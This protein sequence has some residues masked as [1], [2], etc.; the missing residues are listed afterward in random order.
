[1][2]ITTKATTIINFKAQTQ[3]VDAFYKKLE[4]GS[5]VPMSEN[6][7][8]G[9]QALTTEA[10]QFQD[11]IKQIPDDQITPD[12]YEEILKKQKMLIKEGEKLN[13]KLIKESGTAVGETIDKIKNQ[14]SSLQENI[15]ETRESISKEEKK[16][17]QVQDAS[18]ET[19]RKFNVK[20]DET[21]FM[22]ETAEGMGLSD[23]MKGASGKNIK[24]TK[25]MLE[26]TQKID[27]T[28]QSST[29]A[30]KKINE[31]L[32]SG[33][34]AQ[35]AIDSLT[36]KQRETLEKRIKLN[37]KNFTLEEAIT[38]VGIKRT[39]DVEKESFLKAKDIQIADKE[40]DLAAKLTEEKKL[41]A[42][43]NEEYRKAQERGTKEQKEQLEYS[44]QLGNTLLGAGSKASTAYKD[45]QGQIKGTNDSL[46]N[47]TKELHT[48][49]TTL[50]RAT[51]Q[52]FNYGIAF[53]A[54]RRIYRE[55][56]GTIRDLDKALTEMAIVTS[57]N[58]SEV[59]ELV[60]Q[61]QELAKETG[62]TTTEVAKLSTVYFRQGRTLGEVIELTRVAAQAARVAGI[63]ASQSADFLTSAV[64]AFRLS[65]DE[66]LAVSDR[67]AALAAQSASSYEELAV[68]LSKF[69]AQANVAGVGIDF[70]MG[71]LAKGVET[72]REA[73]ETIGT[74]IKT[75]TARMRE[76]T[77]LGKTFE[78]GMDI[79]RVETALRQVGVA[80]RDESGQFRNLEDVLTDIGVKWETLNKNQQASIAVSLAG[81]RQQSRLIAIMNDFERTQELVNISQESAGATTAQQAQFMQGM[82]AAT[83]S[84][85]TAYQNFI[86]TIT[87]SE[88]IIGI[89]RGL[90]GALDGFSNFLE[91]IGL[92]GRFAMTVLVSLF[93]TLKFGGGI[94]NIYNKIKERSTR[95]QVLDNTITE[96]GIKLEKQKMVLEQKNAGIIKLKNKLENTNLGIA[97][98]KAIQDKLET[99]QLE[100]ENVLDTRQILL[101]EQQ[102]LQDK[103]SLVNETI[104]QKFRAIKNSQLAKTNIFTAINTKLQALK[105]KI[106]LKNVG[107]MGLMKKGFAGILS[108]LSGVSKGILGATKATVKFG[109]ALLTTPLGWIAIGLATIVAG[110]FA[111]VRGSEDAENGV[112]SFAATFYK[113]FK[114]LGESIGL[115]IDS[116]SDF[117]KQAKPILAFFG[118]PIIT[119]F[120]NVLNMIQLVVN[121][122]VIAMNKWTIQ[123][124][125]AGEEGTKAFSGLI[126]IIQKVFDVFKWFANSY[127][128]IW[129]NL[130]NGIIK[131]LNLVIKGIN[132]IPGIKN[133]PLLEEIDI[134]LDN[135]I[136]KVQDFSSNLEEAAEESQKDAEEWTKK[137]KLLSN[138]YEEL[139]E[140]LAE[141][142]RES[143]A[144]NY[145]LK[146]KNRSLQELIDER[147]EL[148]RLEDAGLFGEEEEER[149]QSLREEIA[150]LD[151]DLKVIN[152]G[153]IDVDAS[154]N[155]ILEDINVNEEQIRKN[156]FEVAE[157]ALILAEKDFERFMTGDLGALSDVQNYLLN[158]ANSTLDPDQQLSERQASGLSEYFAN[159][160]QTAA[161]SAGENFDPTNLLIFGEDLIGSDQ[162]NLLL[163]S[164][165]EFDEISSGG[166]ESIVD[167]KEVFEDL[168]Q[169]LTGDALKAF[170]E[171]NKNI[172]QLF[173]TISEENI[174]KY[175]ILI[176]TIGFS[177]ESL[178]NLTEIL[179]DTG[180]SLNDFISKTGETALKL[181]ES[182][183]ETE[184]ASRAIID[185]ALTLEDGAA[186]ASLFSLAIGR[187][188]LEATQAADQLTSRLDKLN[189][190]QEKFAT[191]DLSD[192]EIFDLIENYSALFADPEFFAAFREGRDLSRF[193]FKEA[194]EQAEEY[195]IQLYAVQSE[196]QA[197]NNELK[198]ATG[199]EA[200]ALTLRQEGLM[201]E[202]A[203][204]IMLTQVRT[205]LTNITKTQYEY[206][207]ALKAF[208]NLS[209]M[210]I[211][212]LEL[213]NRMVE[214][215]SQNIGPALKITSD[216]I[217]DIQSNISNILGE[218]T[219]PNQIYEF[220]DGVVTL[221][222][223]FLELDEATQ[224]ALTNQFNSIESEISNI[225]EVYKTFMDSTISLE[226]EVAS[227]KI[228]VYEEYFAKLDQLEEQRQR[229]LTRE[230][231]VTELTRL[232]SATDEASRRRALELRTELNQLDEESNKS[233]LEEAR[234]TLIQEIED[235]VVRIK[236]TFENI[237]E[238]F[239]RKGELSGEA[240][241]N[242]LSDAGLVTQE[243]WDNLITNPVQEA[244][245][246][247]PEN[248]DVVLP[249]ELEIPIPI[250]E[251]STE[252]STEPLEDNTESLSKLNINTGK[253]NTNTGKLNANVSLLNTTMQKLL[254]LELSN[255]GGGS[256]EGLPELY[257]LDENGVVPGLRKG[258]MVDYT[259][260]AMLHG[261]SSS[262]EAVLNPMQ[263]E[264]FIGLRDAL[265]KITVDSNSTGNINIE[266][267]AISTESMN[268]NQDFK[269]AGE[270]LADAFNS[271]IQRRGITINTNKV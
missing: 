30:Y 192:Q 36:D 45:L 146:Q 137:A 62:F 49:Q 8:K 44:R 73:P 145:E 76:L 126:N 179:Q 127:F 67:F 84:L 228:S 83:V 122:I 72:T 55:T 121:R 238:D 32:A 252:P 132:L 161:E 100:K 267:I 6:L 109:I 166:F 190:S 226:E 201:A 184:A 26:N 104:L 60:P 130:I 159:I 87:D 114:G 35:E 232:Q 203:R 266:K 180:Y 157:E 195:R 82:E 165:E 37:H 103:R 177:S 176:D 96:V 10:K 53:T 20:A 143:E 106:D 237:F 268:T 5:K 42:K 196:L 214:K 217:S 211:T 219:D 243:L 128:K 48:N 251:P 59:S 154:L 135:I 225:F 51:N 215:L 4:Q 240:L 21:R 111:F 175:N 153:Q 29:T 129:N 235:S 186:A 94:M 11:F 216:N 151:E 241:F 182:M 181:S 185:F 107:I 178:N 259:G 160:F 223:A 206:N 46:K 168:S 144:E 221:K 261:N 119:Y 264:M 246:L 138:T 189:E 174:E 74:A 170:N 183:S 110:L 265:E 172:V 239:V 18:G 54:L 173:D 70:A 244:V 140:N 23:Q 148:L 150:N 124:I 61:L 270:N 191:G 101:T 263:T 43:N 57:M 260:L 80:L 194:V 210:G 224:E 93:A 16:F 269:R 258:G 40:L 22:E 125:E 89:V 92:E 1:M 78:D 187:P 91:N 262:P 136:G 233:S 158:I 33:K 69:A 113:T 142:R 202:E 229:K 41:Q 250:E 199:E 71:M 271:A 198:T 99:I 66:A 24:D 47:N 156:L 230:D 162:F 222:S 7:R 38:Q 15:Q 164:I 3:E 19:T 115:L 234:T 134:S 188:L 123:N 95:M 56:L 14:I 97:K 12:L 88:A 204:L 257:K 209:D 207:N 9:F 247:I 2:A 141:V 50:A 86:T 193:L 85:Q 39:L 149:L 65:A 68:G 169:V 200:E 155:L 77:D 116:F 27:A 64:N 13:K 120:K 34:T 218:G 253:L 31:A 208:N 90:A 52:V 102:N 75:V 205:E 63:S 105:N 81:T 248:I 147:E 212:S 117:W 249:E 163:D 79:N 108:G 98:R 242:A 236:E 118:S 58:R 254:P 139:A 255:S 227:E 197:V 220:V 231:L 245:D 17:S 28:L 213:Q 133:I 25:A 112:D 131:G 171:I 152:N 256:T 167:L